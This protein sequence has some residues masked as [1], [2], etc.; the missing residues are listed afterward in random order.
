MKT[1]PLRA[2]QPGE[3]GWRKLVDTEGNAIQEAVAWHTVCLVVDKSQSIGTGSAILWRGRPL[4]LTANHVIKDSR[5]DDIYFHFRH[6]GTMMVA[7]LDEFR[8]HP[9][10]KYKKKVKIEIGRRHASEDLDLAVMEVQGSISA[11]HPVQF[12]AIP[13]DAVTPS[14]G[15]IVV[16]EGNPADLKKT[17]V[18]GIAASYKIIDWSRIKKN[19]NFEPFNPETEFVTKFRAKDIHARGFSGAGVWFDKP[20]DGV[21]HPNLGLAGICTHYYER[22]KL[23][24]AIRIEHIVRFLNEVYPQCART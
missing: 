23:L 19:P 22:L 3:P 10:M 11:D 7:P 6:E 17:V 16:V 4:I 12:F 20:T 9:K 15:T 1:K 5:N 2:P 8:S 21:W 18:P 14:A 24:S 13:E